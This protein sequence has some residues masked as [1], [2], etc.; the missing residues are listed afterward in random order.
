MGR[1]AIWIASIAVLALLAAVVVWPP[2]PPDRAQPP[3]A[4]TTN[5]PQRIVAM[6]PNTV[7]IIFALG[8]G[9]SLVGVGRFCTY[10]PAVD[11]I[12]KIGGLYDPDLE[13]IL[14]LRPNVVVNRGAS[15]A[16]QRL[17]RD[18][19]IVLYT[20]PTDTLPDL[21]RAIDELGALLDRTDQARA[22]VAGIHTDLEAVATRVQG[23]KPVAVLLAMRSPDKIIPLHTVG[24]EPYLNDLIEIAGGRNIFGDST[25]AY[26]Q[27]SPEE[28]LARAPEVIIEA[29][30]GVSV[31]QSTRETIIAQWQEIGPTPAAQ[32]GR[33]HPLT[34]DYVLIPSPRIVLLARQLAELFHPEVRADD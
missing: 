15:A 4:P 6:A 25:V 11:A 16:L 26:P 20:D 17:C 19:G 2:S 18:N 3:D 27:V 13:Q 5:V 10:P 23:R 28:I 7:E 8:A 1:P 31:D 24:R 22:L 9:D 30:P 33:I 34:E 21:Y 32:M 29:M 12:P 14:A